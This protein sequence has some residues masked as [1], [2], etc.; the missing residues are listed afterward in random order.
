MHKNFEKLLRGLKKLG[1]NAEYENG[2]TKGCG[3]EFVGL[4][5]FISEWSLFN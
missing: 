1:W 3:E 2:V 4:N 5:N